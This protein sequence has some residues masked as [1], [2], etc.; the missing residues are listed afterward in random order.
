VL[1]KQIKA[2]KIEEKGKS[3][4]VTR[5]KLLLKSQALILRHQKEIDGIKKKH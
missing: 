5:Q 3:M 1:K 2:L 4:E